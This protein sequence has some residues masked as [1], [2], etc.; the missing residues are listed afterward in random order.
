M[1]RT[2]K[3]ETVIDLG[4]LGSVVVGVPPLPEGGDEDLAVNRISTDQTLTD[5]GIYIVDSSGGIRTVTLPLLSSVPAG[6]LRMQFKRVGANEVRIQRNGGDT[7]EDGTTTKTI[8]TPYGG[9]VC[10]ADDQ[11]TDWY[12]GGYLGSVT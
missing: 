1:A 8:F 9:F 11:A 7:F 10:F 3:R 12:I 6:G 5:Q 4:G 2:P